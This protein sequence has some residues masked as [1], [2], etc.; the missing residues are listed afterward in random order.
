MRIV[1][2]AMVKN[3][4]DIIECFVRY[5]LSILDALIV[6][7]NGSSD[8]TTRILAALHREGLSLHLA[9]DPT[10]AYQ[11]AELTTDL[12]RYA[13]DITGADF[14]VVLDADEFLRALSQYVDVREVLEAT[15]PGLELAYVRWITYVPE[16]LETNTNSE[17]FSQNVLSSIQH[18]RR[19]ETQQVF[20]VIVSAACCSHPDFHLKQGNHDV[21][22][23][24]RSKHEK[25]L[26]IDSLALAHF[27]VRSY[28]QAER[29]Y[30][31][32]WLG[33]LALTKPV[34][35]DWALYYQQF[36]S[37]SV[38]LEDVSRLAYFYNSPDRTGML[39]LVLDPVIVPAGMICVHDNKST[40]GTLATVLSHSERLARTIAGT[41][42]DINLKWPSEFVSELFDFT[43]EPVGLTLM[44]SAVLCH[45]LASSEPNETVVVAETYDT[46]RL[47][48]ILRR[49][50]DVRL[51]KMDLV[52]VGRSFDVGLSRSV[53]IYDRLII[54]STGTMEQLMEDYRV[55]SAA[56]R[57][58]GRMILFDVVDPV[59]AEARLLAEEEL[60]S[61]NGWSDYQVY[62]RFLRT[63]KIRCK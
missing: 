16:V 3:E 30:L 35:F 53:G 51:V 62:N 7:D 43:L 27:P 12:V 28:Q 54:H 29:K 25:R 5:H 15:L 57:P 26:E 20:K 22:D 63:T 6:L 21:V 32:G 47:S 23:I 18:R 2:V 44:E 36:K 39:D 37:R 55:G 34:L 49:I 11:Q 61:V 46:Q 14:V 41:N 50:A 31:L 59:H 56:L 45:W 52:Q 4:E 9:Y 58:G 24:C 19:H 17:R 42:M 38:N 8:G 13:V 10:I 33:N 48:T 60:S 1:G 40:N